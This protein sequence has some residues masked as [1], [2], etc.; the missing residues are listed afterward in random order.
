MFL[1]SIVYVAID[2]AAAARRPRLCRLS[3]RRALAAAINSS[4]TLKDRFDVLYA[5]GAT[6][7]NMMSV[8]PHCRLSAG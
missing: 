8:G 5:E 1:A 4:A 7:P 6:S 3:R 2:I